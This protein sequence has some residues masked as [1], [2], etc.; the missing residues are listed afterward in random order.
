MGRK[1]QKEYISPTM[2]FYG[3]KEDPK[4]L[5]RSPV[6]LNQVW[7]SENI[8]VW[9]LNND[10]PMQILDA[11]NNSPTAISCLDSIE[12]FMKGNKFTDESLMSLPIDKDGTTLWELH[13]QLCH[14][15][16][17][18]ESYATRFTFDAKQ[19][20]TNCYA[21][22]PETIRFVKPEVEKSARINQVK[23]N[24]YWGTINYKNKELTR[25]YDMWDLSRVKS[26]QEAEGTLYGGQVYFYGSLRA[27]YKFYPVPK[28]WAG[29]HWIY[30]DAAIAQFHH[31]NTE[32]GFFQSMLM[33]MI[34][35]PSQPSKNPKYQVE[36]TG[37]DNVKRKKTTKTVGEEFSDMMSGQFS[38]V[39]KAGNAMVLWAMNKDNAPSVQAFPANQKFDVL[40]GTLTDTTRG[41]T[42]ATRVQAI[43]TNLPQ[44]VS[45]L[46][47]DG[48]SM[49]K[50]VELMQAR[51]SAP[52]KNLENFYNTIVL[53]NLQ[54][55]TAARVKIVNYRPISVAFDVSDKVWEWLNDK[56]K[57]DYLKKNFPDITIDESR[58]AG[59][60]ATTT[61]LDQ[62]GQPVPQP[63]PVPQE[64]GQ[65]NE[66]IKGL[67]QSDINSIISTSNKVAS[68]K[69][70][71]QQGKQILMGFGL[72]E[73][74][75][76]D[77][78]TEEPPT[79]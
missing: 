31:N 42:I 16:T 18:L 10:L 72:T 34:G 17:L 27:P 52:Q 14:N 58:F 12:T 62:N 55:P 60:T 70:T 40:S 19:R 45:S 43:L 54:K 28:Y 25:V 50:A 51:V 69:L 11:V 4:G 68:G 65:I 61:Q 30:T 71:Y 67:K 35:D 2:G 49:Q 7:Q 77:W 79:P 48:N 78:L 22:G 6:T 20:I 24:P 13:C 37:T 47:S 73:S 74:Q 3:S 41:I 44:Q 59:S 64:Q 26:Q 46:G 23:Y 39:K 33:T 75:I 5:E 36:E 32:N 15:F 63:A 38:G 57:A 8:I 66:A 56:E 1:P 29:K 21:L 9:G 53:P 76:K